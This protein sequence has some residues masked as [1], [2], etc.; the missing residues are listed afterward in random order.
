M[1]KID[2]ITCSFTV[3]YCK[4]DEAF[5]KADFVAAF[6]NMN[7]ANYKNTQIT[8]TEAILVSFLPLP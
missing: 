2:T 6:K 8:L 3:I 4:K 5:I 1:L 7:E